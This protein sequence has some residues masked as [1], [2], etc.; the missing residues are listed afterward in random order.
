MEIEYS[1]DIYYSNKKKIPIS[2]VANAL[3]ALEEVSSLAPIL[4]ERLF[5][6]VTVRNISI[7]VD[8]IHSGS[9]T[10]KIKYYL[11]VAFQKNI[12]DQSGIDYQNLEG[13]S[14]DTKSNLIGWLL[15]ASLVVALKYAADKAFP[16]EE[17]PN[18]QNQIN[19]TIQAGRD[20]TGMSEE[21]LLE[22]IENVVRENPDSVHGAIGFSNP[23][24]KEEGAY[25]K[26]G[27]EMEL[28]SE[29]LREVPSGLLD[30]EEQE[31]VIELEATDIYIR[32]TDKDSGKTGWGAT[33]PEFSKKRMRMHIAPGIDLA[34]L[35]HM[36]VVVGN[37]AIFYTIDNEGKI[38]RPH[39][40][41]FGIDKERSISRNSQP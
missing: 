40:H 29:L 10:E 9:L 18:I 20:I 31:R 17:K 8:E 21:K 6:D 26:L 25:L 13:K 41:L 33:I 11:W 4:L 35:S 30:E 36:D 28:S 12:E 15:A 1:Q 34:F 14:K 32:A 2:E 22:T 38:R 37:V 5:D 7:Y 24:K 39:V 16:N 3:L 23:A 27:Q 19:V